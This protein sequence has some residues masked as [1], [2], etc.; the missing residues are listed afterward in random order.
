MPRTAA[1][2]LKRSEGALGDRLRRRRLLIAPP[3]SLR[4][5]TIDLGCYTMGGTTAP[6]AA[7]TFRHEDRNR[8][9]LRVKASMEPS[10]ITMG[11]DSL[12]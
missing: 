12:W 4:M 8:H 7:R 2:R 9:Q 5:D 1:E 11:P 6:A 3:F 10:T